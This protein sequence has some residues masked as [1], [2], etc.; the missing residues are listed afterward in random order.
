MKQTARTKNVTIFYICFK[1]HSFHLKMI[2]Q[3]SGFKAKRRETSALPTT[4]LRPITQKYYHTFITLQTRSYIYNITHVIADQSF[5]SDL[6]IS[7][8]ILINLYIF[9]TAFSYFFGQTL[10]KILL[11]F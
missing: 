1:S 7:F 4:P 2:D 11:Q 10:R 9:F 3:E 5:L 8:Q 6:H